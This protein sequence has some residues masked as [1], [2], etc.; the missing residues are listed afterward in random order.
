MANSKCGY[1]AIIGRPNVGKSTLLNEII[2]QK[3]SITSHKQQTTRHVIHGIKTYDSVQIVYVDTPGIH[4]ESKRALNQYMNRAARSA[5]GEV[6]VIL[7]IISIEHWTHNDELV[8]KQLQHANCPVILVVNKI[9][10]VPNKGELL[11]KLDELSKKMKFAEIVPISATK[12]TN[13]T[14][15]EKVIEKYLPE[16]PHFFQ[17]EQITDQND[18]F[19]IAEII[20]EKLFK[21]VHQEVP[22]STTVMVEEI[23]HEDKLMRIYATI[24]VEK[25]GQ[26]AIIIGKQGSKLKQIGREARLELE[27][28][29]GNKIF[30]QLWVKIKTEWSENER[31]LKQF[32]FD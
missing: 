6:D 11:I 7:F 15:L 19:L 29:Y 31:T 24:Y 25:S 18:G 9:D 16:G 3:I 17:A 26:K 5:T 28:M 8:L 1:V 21:W 20:R 32:G 12:K 14:T 23:K 13:V 4:T 27:K 30:L 10:T 2:G 22:Y